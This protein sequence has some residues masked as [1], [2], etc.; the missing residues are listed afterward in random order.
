MVWDTH[1]QPISE[2]LYLHYAFDITERRRTQEEIE[3]LA[4]FPSENPNPVL[5]MSEGGAVLYANAASSDLLKHWACA[6]GQTLPDHWRGIVMKSL[7]QGRPQ[8]CDMKCGNRVYSLTFA[9]VKN[10]GFVNIYGLDITEHRRTEQERE[11]TLHDTRERVKELTCMYGVARL[12]HTRKAMDEILQ[13]AVMLIPPG[14]HYP[15]MTRGKIR[16]ADKEFVS[17][18]FTETQWKQTSDIVVQGEV[19][20]SVEVYYLEPCPELDEG[21]FMKEERHLINGIARSLGEAIGHRQMEEDLRRES[22]MRNTLLDHLPCVALILKK[23]TREI[24]ASNKAA[25]EIGAVPGK[26]CYGTSAQRDDHCPF[27]LAPECWATDEPRRVEVEYRGAYYEGIW[28]PL[29]DELYVHYI[30][31][32]TDRKR[33]EQEASEAQKALLD[34]QRHETERVASELAAVRDE[35][36]RKTRLAAVGQ[37]SASIAHDLRNPLGVVRNSAFFLKRRFGKIDPK[38]TEHLEII[39]EDVSRSDRIITNLLR[40]SRAK[41]PETEDV[42]LGELIK[43]IVTPMDRPHQITWRICVDPEPFILQADPS[44]LTQVISNIWDNAVDAMGEQG[45]F[46]VEATREADTDT[47]IL[48]DTGPGFESAVRDRL[49]EPLVTTKARGTGLG[50][51]ICLQII[52]SHGGTIEAFET[53]DPG[54]ALRIQLPRR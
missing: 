27:C 33:S 13:D 17:E 9:P 38:L 7:A 24:V 28:V 35:L 25:R 40:M 36:V 16:F 48:R 30:F 6:E 19:C 39:N 8:K 45:Q 52:E 42:D 1:W 18:P 20:G 15:E 50:L 14:W 37:V 47:I 34:Q 31:D 32:I 10:A 22:D 26:T 51:T 21:P 43:T 23:G 54:A 3:R 46:S 41:A 11:R 2:E 44:L 53:A 4:K 49:F 12:I 5:R 29:T